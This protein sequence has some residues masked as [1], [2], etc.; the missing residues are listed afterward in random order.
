MKKLL[1][2]INIILILIFL[3]LIR[4]FKI[5]VNEPIPTT[6][7]QISERK[8]KK[9]NQ[10]ENILNNGS[11]FDTQSIILF[12]IETTIEELELN[13]EK[14]SPILIVTCE[15]FLDQV[16]EGEKYNPGI[17]HFSI[18]ISYSYNGEGSNKSFI[19]LTNQNITN[20]DFSN[21]KS[22]SVT[23]DSIQH[24]RYYLVISLNI[25]IT[26]IENDILYYDNIVSSRFNFNY[27]DLGITPD[28]ITSYSIISHNNLYYYDYDF[29][30]H[31]ISEYAIKGEDYGYLIGKDYWYNYGLAD[32]E[33]GFSFSWLSA[34][35]D[36]TNKILN[37]EIIQGLKLWYIIGI[38]ALFSLVYMLL[39][40]FR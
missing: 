28:T 31:I 34:L 1:L 3:I 18:N 26:S 17:T 40:L 24:F 11:D 36:T 2:S 5:I 37:V 39:K 7:T 20:Y 13:N 25:N 15:A 27:T 21:I 8:I 14:V 22:I 6:E 16:L 9:A 32:G 29:L 35:F 33:N 4:Y 38:P 10:I 23:F 19:I 12:S 30:L